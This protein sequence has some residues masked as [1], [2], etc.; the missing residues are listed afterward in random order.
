MKLPLG[1]AVSWAFLCANLFNSHKRPFWAGLII[2]FLLKI[3]ELR[4]PDSKSR[5]QIPISISLDPELLCRALD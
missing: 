2:V 3:R 1:W 4:R 5:R